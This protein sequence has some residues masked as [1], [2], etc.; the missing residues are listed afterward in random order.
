MKILFA[1]TFYHP[2]ISGLTV[3]VQRIAE[4]L[5]KRNYEVEVITSQYDKR[6]SR[7][8]IITGVTIKRIPYLFKLL[9]A[10]F[11]PF[12]ALYF[13]TLFLPASGKNHGT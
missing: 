7:E 5:A 11:M 8:E 3:H 9:K 4:N 2:Y 6:L 12:Y 10:V 1:T 13:F